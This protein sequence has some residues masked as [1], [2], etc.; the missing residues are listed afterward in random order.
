MARGK[1]AVAAKAVAPVKPAGK[2]KRAET[3]VPEEPAP[4]R[5]PASRRPPRARKPAAEAPPPVT[6]PSH[7]E[8]SPRSPWY[9]LCIPPPSA[10]LRKVV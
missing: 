8:V 10:R 1:R 6:H 3:K 7:G 5:A 2:R 9:A 4:K